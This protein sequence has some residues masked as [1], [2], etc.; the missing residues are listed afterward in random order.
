M[1]QSVFKEVDQRIDDT[2]RDASRIASAVE[3]ELEEGVHAAEHA[4][5]QGACA[6]TE[7]FNNTKQRLQQHPREAAAAIFVAGIAAGAAIAWIIKKK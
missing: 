3:N 6:A 4:A 7:L 2:K 1:D 5:K